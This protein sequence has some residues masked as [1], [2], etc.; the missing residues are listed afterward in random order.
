MRRHGGRQC[1]KII[2]TFEC[3][4]HAALAEIIGE[5]A[6]LP[7]QPGEI[8]LVPGQVGERI[9]AVRVEARRRSG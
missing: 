4:D 5:R 2:A 7:G 9:G 1:R 8:R 3:R 6:K